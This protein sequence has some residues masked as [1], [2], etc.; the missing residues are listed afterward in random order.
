MAEI[1]SSDPKCTMKMESQ[2]SQNVLK[3]GVIQWQKLAQEQI[4]GEKTIS[5]TVNA[6]KKILVWKSEIR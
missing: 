2:N 4:Y 5:P 3:G 1:D 6:Q